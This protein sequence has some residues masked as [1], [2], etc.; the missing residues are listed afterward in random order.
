MMMFCGS[1]VLPSGTSP[2]PFPPGARGTCDVTAAASHT[3]YR[4][5]LVHYPFERLLNP[6]RRG[7]LLRRQ[8]Q[9]R[10]DDAAGIEAW[11]H[12][13]QREGAL[14][15]QRRAG[16]KHEASAS[17]AAMSVVR[18]RSFTPPMPGLRPPSFKTDCRSVRA[19][20]SAGATPESSAVK[21]VTPSAKRTT[22]DVEVSLIEPRHTFRACLDQTGN[23]PGRERQARRSSHRRHHQAFD[24][25]LTQHATAARAERRPHRD[26]SGAGCASG[27]KQVRNVRARNQQHDD[28]RAEEARIVASD[29]RRRIPASAKPPGTTTPERLSETARA[30]VARLHQVSVGAARS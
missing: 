23:T 18:R 11:R 3:G 19:A 15:E 9:P 20:R 5:R 13:L 8:R 7:V 27:E 21:T 17:S 28:D 1:G 10:A 22:R 29:N 16:Q 6:H 30:A 24:E 2:L 26:L 4:S 25:Q 14:N 12:A